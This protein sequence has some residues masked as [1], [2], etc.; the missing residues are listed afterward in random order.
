MGEDRCQDCQSFVALHEKR[1]GGGSRC[2]DDKTEGRKAV[3]A[4]DYA[5]A[6]FVRV[7]EVEL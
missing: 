6:S 2:P 7:G 4:R 1:W 3:Y 5:C